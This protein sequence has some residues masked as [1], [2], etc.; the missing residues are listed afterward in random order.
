MN[1]L[2]KIIGYIC[3]LP[4][5]WK[6]AQIDASSYI[7]PGYDWFNVD[8][9]GLIIKDKV[10]I[11]R[12]AWIE[13]IKTSISPQIVIDTQTQI[14]R[15]AMISA[16][17]G[18]KI[19]RK[20]VI[21]YGVSIID[22]DHALDKKNISPIDSGLTPGQPIIISNDCFVGAHSFILKGVTLGRQCVVGANSVVTKSFP[23]YSIVVGNPAKLVRKI[24]S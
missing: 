21:S 23:S 2:T 20:C 11:G 1:N 7:G 22:H 8:L 15:N 9:R 12:N 6:G 16:S 13:I 24:K 19:G 18:I 14:G 3:T 10:V 4:A 5:R 17:S